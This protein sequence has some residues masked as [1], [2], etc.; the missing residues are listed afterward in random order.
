MKYFVYFGS[1]YF[2]VLFILTDVDFN[3]CIYFCFLVFGFCTYPCNI[4]FYD[5]S[6]FFLNTATCKNSHWA[7]LTLRESE[8]NVDIFT[9]C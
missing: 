3:L 6:D 5:A 2:H 8:L 4:S 1:F 7:S 9:E